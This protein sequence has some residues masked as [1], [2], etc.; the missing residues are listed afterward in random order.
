MTINNLLIW[1]VPIKI[2]V[3]FTSN[4]TLTY[5]YE[6]RWCFSNFCLIVVVFY[7]FSLYHILSTSPQSIFINIF[8]PSVKYVPCRCIWSP[9][10]VDLMYN[11]FRSPAF[12]CRIHC[13]NIIHNV[14]FHTPALPSKIIS[15]LYMLY[16]SKW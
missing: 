1:W 2:N 11:Y 6:K 7:C 5:Q 10:Y 13:L 4:C 14:C 15:S 9:M 3:Y 8:Q 12:S 16:R